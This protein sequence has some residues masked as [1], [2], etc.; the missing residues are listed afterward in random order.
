LE[1]NVDDQILELEEKKKYLYKKLKKLGNFRRGTISI[2]YRK[3]GEKKC[4]CA[5]SGHPGHGPQYLWTTTIKKKSYSKSL[6]MG[7]ELQ[8]YKEETENYLT[9]MKLYKEI[10][11]VNEKLCNLLPPAEL[12]QKEEEALKKKLQKYFKQKLKK[13]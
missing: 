6:K 3:C 11:Q 5:K 7:P 13:K 9:F 2:H 4:A 12:S 8:K 10:I 1:E